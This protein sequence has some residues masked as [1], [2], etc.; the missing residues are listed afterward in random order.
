MQRDE[1]IGIGAGLNDL[2]LGIRLRYEVRR[3]I[4]PYIGLTWKESFGATHR[5]TIQ[6]GGDPAHFVILAGAR[7]WF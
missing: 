3:E 6:E 7:V 2:E 1:E 5:L 4:A